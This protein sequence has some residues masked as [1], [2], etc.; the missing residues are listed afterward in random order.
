MNQY[1]I[2]PATG[3]K[4]ATQIFTYQA[5]LPSLANSAS[6]TTIINF[7]ADS[8][9]VWTKTTLTAFDVNNAPLT[10]NSEFI[11]SVTAFIRD[12]GSGRNL[13]QEPV[14]VSDMA[15]NGK[16]PYFLQKPFV[17]KP[18]A[19]AQFTYENLSG[20]ADYGRFGLVLHGYKIW[21][22]GR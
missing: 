10:N 22:D 15:G 12:T 16:L 7:E 21:R 9:F 19:T 11:A 20:S 8:E 1:E 3:K 4:I 2:D 6:N 18:K 17:W 14:I 13:M 5:V